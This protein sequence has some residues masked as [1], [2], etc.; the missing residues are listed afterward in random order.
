MYKMPAR[1]NS[2]CLVRPPYPKKMSRQLVMRLTRPT[3][4]LR[5]FRLPIVRPEQSGVLCLTFRMQASRKV[6]TTPP[7]SSQSGT[8]KPRPESNNTLIILSALGALG[9]LYYYYTRG[10]PGINRENERREEEERRRKVGGIEEAGKSKV[11]NIATQ[12]RRD[13]DLAKVR[14]RIHCQA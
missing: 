11:E 6:T 9:G 14:D 12:G 8:D 4:Y 5:A 3:I 7:P 2:A 10:Q 13:Y 1:W